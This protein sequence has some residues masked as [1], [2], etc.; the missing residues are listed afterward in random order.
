MSKLTCNDDTST[1]TPQTSQN[2]QTPQHQTQ[3]ILPVST[4]QNSTP[5]FKSVVT[6]RCHYVEQSL[7]IKIIQAHLNFTCGKSQFEELGQIFVEISEGTANV[8]FISSIVQTE[9]GSKY[10]L[11]TNDGLELHDSPGT[12]GTNIEYII[13]M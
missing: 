7:N 3:A 8:S 10:I 13:N 5:I 9:L 1:S 6:S 4:L 2:S 12:R 11:V